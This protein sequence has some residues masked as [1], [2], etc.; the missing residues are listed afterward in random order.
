MPVRPQHEVE[1]RRAKVARYVA[2]GL[3]YAEIA[4]L[5]G[6]TS[7][8]VYRDY[9]AWARTRSRRLANKQDAAFLEILN[10]LDE[11]VRRAWE[12][13]AEDKTEP[14]VRRELL[15]TISK[16]LERKAR[17][18]GLL[19]DRIGGGPQ[20]TT[21]ILA[22]VHPAAAAALQTMTPETAEEIEGEFFAL[23]EHAES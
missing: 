17:L 20:V 18:M 10:G 23:P 1:E 4:P 2:R 22:L 11:T 5:L 13:I 16:T 21:N 15:D 12:E 9:T 3:S 6:V 19:Q 14:K 7:Q 8:Q